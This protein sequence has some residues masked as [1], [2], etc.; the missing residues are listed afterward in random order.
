M[1]SKNLSDEAVLAILRSRQL[2]RPELCAEHVDRWLRKLATWYTDNR[3]L[4]EDLA[5]DCMVYFLETVFRWI[6]P[7]ELKSVKASLG[8][9]MNW[10]MLDLTDM[11]QDRPVD[12]ERLRMQRSNERDFH[13]PYVDEFIESCSPR[14]KQVI[15][16]LMEG[17]SV[18]E[19]SEILGTSRRMINKIRHTVVV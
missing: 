16:L 12:R 14:Q 13:A 7:R 9:V 6:E 5:Q 4:Q 3:T 15:K 2:G 8:I 1:S 11:Y 17:H 19:A 18:T 10:R